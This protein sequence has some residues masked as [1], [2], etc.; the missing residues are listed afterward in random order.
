M[1]IKEMI[2]SGYV[3]LQCF[4]IIYDGTGKSSGLPRGMSLVT[5]HVRLK[6]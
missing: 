4:G 5:Q 1:A 3:R 6:A 2:A